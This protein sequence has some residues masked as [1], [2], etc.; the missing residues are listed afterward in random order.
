MKRLFSAAFVIVALF[1]CSTAL[2]DDV[3][4]LFELFGDEALRV[5]IEARVIED[6]DQTVWNMEL[7]RVTI[8]GRS[9]HVRLDGDNIIIRAQFTPY[10]NDDSL[11]LVAHGQTWLRTA[12]SDELRYETAFETVPVELGQAVVFYP[13]GRESV[14]M[15]LDTQRYGTVNLE[16]EITVVPYIQSV[17]NT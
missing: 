5:R 7:T 14:K 3:D 17:E 10:R 11:L 13:L 1:V 15:D 2:A 16:L 8:S 6:G 9:V 12:D 4:E